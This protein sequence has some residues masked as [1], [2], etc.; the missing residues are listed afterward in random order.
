MNRIE[1]G[2]VKLRQAINAV[3]PHNKT[4]WFTSAVITAAGSGERMGGVSKQLYLLD[5]TPC[6]VHTVRAFESLS[7]IDEI[8]IVARPEERDAILVLVRENNFKKVTKVVDGGKS[9]ME[10]VRN[11][12]YAI[13]QK[14]DLVAIHDGDRPLITPKEIETIIKDA[15]RYGAATAAKKMTDS[16]KRCDENGMILHSVPRDDLYTVQTPQIFLTDLYRAS[17]AVT[18]DAKESAT[19]DNALAEQAGFKVKLTVT[20]GE[21]IKLTTLEDVSRIE[22]VLRERHQ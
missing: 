18:K 10:S 5:G 8:V 12:F 2:A 22:R 14:A 16:V 19:D 3:F 1:I 4:R 21:N 7:D 6:I 11:G 20:N 9:R 15:K 17:L 13:D